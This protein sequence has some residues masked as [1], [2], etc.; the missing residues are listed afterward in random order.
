LSAMEE[1]C[2]TQ[3]SGVGCSSPQVVATVVR[4]HDNAVC[5]DFWPAEH[6]R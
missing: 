3:V 6:C 1:G 4:E 5:G 2:D